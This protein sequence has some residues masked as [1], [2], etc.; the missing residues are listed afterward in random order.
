VLS[1]LEPDY[2][3]SVRTHA[4]NCFSDVDESCSRFRLV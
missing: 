2:K 3:T 1:G 4:H